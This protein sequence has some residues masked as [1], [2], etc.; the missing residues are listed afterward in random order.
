MREPPLKE[1]PRLPEAIFTI[2]AGIIKLNYVSRYTG[3]WLKFLLE[4]CVDFMGAWFK[5]IAP[6]A[7][8]YA[9][10]AIRAS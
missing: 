2:L 10:F 6:P 7:P 9:N 3:N 5:Y 1:S 4:G 8:C